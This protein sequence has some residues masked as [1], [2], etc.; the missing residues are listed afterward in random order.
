MERKYIELNYKIKEFGTIIIHRHSRP[1]GDAIGSQIGLKE[2]IKAT[3]PYK[4]VY[5]VGDVSDKFKFLGDMDE[6][7]DEE[8]KQALVIVLDSGDEYLISDERYKMGRY[9]VKIDHHIAKCKWECAKIEIIDQEEISCASII[10]KMVFHLHYKLTDLGA[11]AL[12]TGIVTDSGR[13]RYVGTSYKTFDV[14]SKLLKYHFSMEDVYS[15]IYV[16]DVNVIK[17]RAKLTMKFKVSEGGVAYLINTY[18]EVKEYDTDIF[19]ISRGMVGV[20]SGIKGINAW[21]NFTEDENKNVIAELRC[22]SKF[23]V[24][25]VAVKWG[26]G[27]HKQAS[28]A[29]LKSIDDVSKVIKDLE[30]VLKEAN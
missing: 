4:K 14:V 29:T 26:G 2:A 13:F 10:A 5:A 30:N 11:K 21:A 1:D 9:I 28:G 16:E 25:K 19:T 7:K 27:G 23:N 12:F 15:N 17:L 22:T 6:V 18:D 3:Y 24:N 8:Y 20:M